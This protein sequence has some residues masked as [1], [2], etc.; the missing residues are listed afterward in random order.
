M[1]LGGTVSLPFSG[2]AAAQQAMYERWSSD[3]RE[4]P[5][6]SN[7]SVAPIWEIIP[8]S[9]LSTHPYL[10]AN[11]Q[12]GVQDYLVQEMSRLGIVPNPPTQVPV[13]AGADNYY[14]C[15]GTKG[16]AHTY[17][18]SCVAQLGT[19]PEIESPLGPTVWVQSSGSR[20]CWGNSMELPPC[21]TTTVGGAT[22]TVTGMHL[23]RMDHGPQFVQSSP[24]TAAAV[25]ACFA[26]HDDHP[27]KC[28]VHDHQLGP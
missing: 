4:N 26:A 19:G 8:S 7:M 25:A 20:T 12:R 1:T 2:D 5:V 14:Y 15:N 16:N 3:V 22:L 10:T 18:Y 21:P 28:W 27:P 11:L 6:I 13:W 24:S 9:L 17:A 23:Y